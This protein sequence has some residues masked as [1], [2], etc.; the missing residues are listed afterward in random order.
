MAD[1]AKPQHPEDQYLEPDR[2]HRRS[3]CGMAGRQRQR[4][5]RAWHR[6]LRHDRRS[7]IA[8]TIK[9]RLRTD[10]RSIE[11]ANG[12]RDLGE[13]QRIAVR[14]GVPTP[15]PF[16]WGIGCPVWTSSCNLAQRFCLSITYKG[17]SGPNRL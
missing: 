10:R 4:L 7:N 1:A 11:P 15:P 5:A 14:R 13:V 8:A 2:A 3:S 9:A 12:L 16:G 6:G 17:F